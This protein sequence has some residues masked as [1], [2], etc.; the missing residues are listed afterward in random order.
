MEFRCGSDMDQMEIIYHANGSDIIQMPSHIFV[1]YPS[2]MHQI[3]VYGHEHVSSDII[4][5]PDT[6]HSAIDALGTEDPDGAAKTP[7]SQLY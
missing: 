3:S 4:R 7:Q 1:I 6:A 5:Y 2:D